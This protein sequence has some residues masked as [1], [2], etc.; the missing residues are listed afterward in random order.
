MHTAPSAHRRPWL[1]LLIGAALLPFATLQPVLPLAAWLAPIFLLR[2]VRA[3]RV[4]VG[5]PALAVV[6]ALVLAV[7]MALGTGVPLFALSGLVAGLLLVPAYAADRLLA[8]RLLG[9]K[10]SLVFP[11]AAAA[12]DWLD[13]LLAWKIS[14]LPLPSIFGVAGIFDSPGYSQVGNLPLVQLVAVTGMWG[15][16]F[17]IAWAASAV[18]ELWERGFA[19]RA[20]RGTVGAFAATLLLTLLFGTARL[21]FS[22][23]PAETV[24]VVGLVP[25][26]DI[27]NTSVVELR[28]GDLMPGTPEDR[29]LARAAFAPV[30]DELLARSVSEA[31]A[32][33]AVVM[34]AEAAAPVLEEDVPTLLARAA[35]L[36]RAEQ[37]YLQLGV[38][39]FRNSANFPFMQNRAILFDPRGATLW[40][41]HKANP[42]PGENTLVAAGPQRVPTAV[43]P[44]GILAAVL[45]YDTDFPQLVRQAGQAGAALLLTGYKDWETIRQQHAEMAV[46]SAV[47]NGLTVVRP[48]LSGISTSVDA[49]GR[50][51]AQVDDFGNDRPTLVAA[52][53]TAGVPTLYA[54]FG[55]W[56]A[57][58]CLAGL[59]ALVITAFAQPARYLVTPQPA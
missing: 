2:F 41:Y 8:P 11:L 47:A 14:A 33:A 58:L 7:D 35:A 43:T 34:W 15:L 39:V 44:H 52:V 38:M 50:T 28:P 27:T 12:T 40:D 22:P 48:A 6:A 29:A 42:T 16:T 3:T 54:R 19:L 30:T 37:I 51:L 24:R 21:A 59:A 36:A 46:F 5:L 45:C 23:V 13:T 49:Y 10:R 4:R 57:Y 31:R 26:I 56:F 18:N 32:G 55:D 25:S 53:A 9:L 20:A 1:W 17:L